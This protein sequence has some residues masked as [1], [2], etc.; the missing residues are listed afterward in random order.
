MDTGKSRGLVYFKDGKV[1]AE[2]GDVKVYSM[3][4]E[5][6]LEIGPGHTLWALEGESVDYMEQLYDKPRGDC[7]EIGLGL[8]VASRYILSCPKVT[9]LTTVEINADVIDVYEQVRSNSSAYIDEHNYFSQQSHTILN[10]NG[11]IYAYMTKAT[12]DFIFIDCYA[13]ID[14][15]TLPVIQDM[16]V[17]C[18]K[19]L[20]KGGEIIG[21]LDKYTP[22]KDII[23]FNSLFKKEER[24]AT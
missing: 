20:K 14:E 15:D 23:K 10:A 22:Q 7:L 11:L 5:L 8:G 16:V 6:F 4:R 19:L 17:A 13:S 12:Y 1:I 2:S 9:S 21:W 18:R 24:H 3:N